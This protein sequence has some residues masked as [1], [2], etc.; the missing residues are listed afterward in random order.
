MPDALWDA[1]NVA[2]NT[3]DT[4]YP[5]TALKDSIE[6]QLAA[7]IIIKSLDS[8]SDHSQ[9]IF[10]HNFSLYYL[11]KC[12]CLAEAMTLRIQPHH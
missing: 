1:G 11:S 3:F 2:C 5:G 10:D 4:Q 12:E 9:L 7:L 8:R 6:V